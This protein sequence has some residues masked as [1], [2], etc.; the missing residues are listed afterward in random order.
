M[1]LVTGASGNN[2]MHIVRHLLRTG[3]AVRTLLRDPPK[4]PAKARE[5]LN[6]GCR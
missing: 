3:A 2:G 5:L 6:S 4:E 1:T